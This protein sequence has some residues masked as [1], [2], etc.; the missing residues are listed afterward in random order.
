MSDRDEA[1]RKLHEAIG[2]ASA[3]MY[4]ELLD[5]GARA[6]RAKIVAYLDKSG[7]NLYAPGQPLETIILMWAYKRAA[8]EI[9]GLLHD[10]EAK[11]RDFN[12]RLKRWPNIN[13]EITADAL[14]AITVGLGG[15]GE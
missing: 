6:E 14:G 3:E 2:V 4:E 7:S 15:E 12:N 9:N 5:R 1:I 8:D 10:Y 11:V 13:A